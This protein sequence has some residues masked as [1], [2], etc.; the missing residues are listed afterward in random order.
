MTFHEDFILPQ[1]HP[2]NSL[3]C[4]YDENLSRSVTVRLPAQGVI[5]LKT[6]PFY[7]F[8]YSLVLAVQNTSSHKVIRW[9]S[10][11]WK[12]NSEKGTLACSLFMSLMILITSY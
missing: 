6:V 7:L 5:P 9:R 1:H 12:T 11:S 10:I 8:T 3:C 2:T 4:G